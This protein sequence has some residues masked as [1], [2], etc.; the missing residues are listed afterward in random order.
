MLVTGI[1]L[2]T[3]PPVPHLTG[4]IVLGTSALLLGVG[5]VVVAVAITQLRMRTRLG[6]AFAGMLYIIASVAA[7]ANPTT[8]PIPMLP[9]AIVILALAW[10]LEGV[11]T[12]TVTSLAFIGEWSALYAVL[13][14]LAGCSLLLISHADTSSMFWLGALLA[15]LGVIQFVRALTLNGKD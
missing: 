15:L 11:I 12:F 9:A 6:Y 5:G 8:A 4:T 1:L 14:V 7:V 2:L 3:L 13:C 10:I